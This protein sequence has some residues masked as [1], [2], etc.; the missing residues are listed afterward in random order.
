MNTPDP[1]TCT[2]PAGTRVLVTGATGFTGSVLVRHLCASGVAVRAIARESSD[3]T[4]LKDLDVEWF[5]GEVFDPAVI[6]EAACGVSY[7]FHVA[8]AFREARYDDEHY[9]KVHVTSTQLLVEAAR[10]NPDFKRFIHVSTMGVHGHIPNPPGNE[11][12]PFSPGDIYQVTKLEA[13]EWLRAFAKEHAF[14]MTIIRPCAIFGPD[15]RRLLKVF[16]MALKPVFV[17][18]GY[19]KCLYHLIHVEDLAR[20]LLTAATHPNAEGEAFLAGNT[21]AIP[22]TEMGRIIATEEGRPLRVVRLPVTPVFWLADLCEWVFK[23]IGKEPPLH[24]R[25]VAFF[26]KDRSFDTTK[27]QQKLEYEHLYD[28]RNGLVNTF[29]AYRDKGWI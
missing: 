28:N 5:R 22:L 25:R 7:I 18:L 9:R 23:R 17:V 14:P 16:R 19:G 3:L 27:L 4:P 8:A 2:I 11:Q 12:S 10:H 13:E 6:A 29:H 24:R 21:E 26:T 15:D 20:I 1:W